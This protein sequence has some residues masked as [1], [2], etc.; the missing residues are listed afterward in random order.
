MNGRPR[1]HMIREFLSRRAAKRRLAEWGI[2][3]K[4]PQRRGRSVWV[5]V[6]R[7]KVDT[8]CRIVLIEPR[9]APFY[10]QRPHRRYRFCYSASANPL[11]R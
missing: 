2:S 8:R 11:R 7:S 3:T 1:T 4:L 9:R 10:G 6:P 5:D